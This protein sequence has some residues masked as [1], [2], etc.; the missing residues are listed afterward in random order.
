MATGLSWLLL[1]ITIVIVSMAGA[2][3]GGRLCGRRGCV[4]EYAAVT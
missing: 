2:L 1:A 4:E 3:P